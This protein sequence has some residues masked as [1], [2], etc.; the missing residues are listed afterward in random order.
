[1]SEKI[2]NLKDSAI[3]SDSVQFSL[4]KGPFRTKI[5]GGHDLYEDKNGISQL[6]EILFET[7]NT[8]VLGGALFT[9]E[10]IFG[11]QSPLNVEY[12]NT[13]MG[14]ANTG[15]P[16]VEIYPKDNVVCLFGVGIGGSGET[17]TSVKDV[18]FHE[19]EIMDMIPFRMTDEALTTTDA[20]KYWFKKRMDTTK[21]AYYLKK[22]ESNPQIKALWKDAEGDNDGTEVE[23]GVHNTTRVEPIE[24]FVEIILKINKNDCRE[25]FEVN[26]NIEQTRVN[27]VGLF[28]GIKS[29]LEDG[30]FDY[31]QVKMFSKLN[32]NNEMLTL[33]KDLTIVYRIYTS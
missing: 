33:A 16:V 8:I 19:R 7:E 13:I 3:S 17:I 30:T 14:I 27:S 12:L 26:G 5:M 1:M 25:W 18:K 29:P 32:I 15:T 4:D 11:V 20:A 28:T 6:G 24:S 23:T 21:T 9:L 2:L 31:K 10:K 22:F